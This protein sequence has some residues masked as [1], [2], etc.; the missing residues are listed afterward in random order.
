MSC[1]RPK[2]HAAALA[3]NKAKESLR[4]GWGWR[5]LHQLRA[6]ANLVRDL[7]PNGRYRCPLY[8]SRYGTSLGTGACGSRGRRCLV[9]GTFAAQ[10]GASITMAEYGQTDSRIAGFASTERP[11]SRPRCPLVDI[12]RTLAKAQ[13]PA[14][15]RRAGWQTESFCPKATFFT[16]SC[17]YGSAPSL[18]N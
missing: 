10:F 9:D 17:S 1:G 15:S 13:R 3:L 5:G 6:A 4:V 11:F 7:P 12:G 2:R 16:D 8:P 14:Q 18:A